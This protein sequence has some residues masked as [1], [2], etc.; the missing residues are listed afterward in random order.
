MLAQTPGFYLIALT[1]SMA[2]CKSPGHEATTP[3]NDFIYAEASQARELDFH[4]KETS[5]LLQVRSGLW[6]INDSKNPGIIYHIDPS[7]GNLLDQ[8]DLKTANTDWEDLAADSSFFYVADIGNNLGARQHLSI[9]RIS[10]AV[11]EGAPLT[12]IDTINFS[13]P[14]QTSFPGNYNHNFDAEALIADDGGLFLFTKNWKNKRCKLYEIPN[15]PGTHDARFIS[16]FN[17]QGLIT[18]ATKNPSTGEIYL[19]GYGYDGKNTPFIWILSNFQKGDYFSGTKVRYNIKLNRQTEAIAVLAN[20]TVV[21]SA[22]QAK[23]SAPGMWS[24][25]WD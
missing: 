11:L 2:A 23:A 6:T 8:V 16:E 7:T 1:I 5:G 19:L 13:Y 4:V 20:G 12:K 18:A 15:Q 21:I 17:S 24:I 10:L 22:E 25:S 9:Y 14:E 3:Q